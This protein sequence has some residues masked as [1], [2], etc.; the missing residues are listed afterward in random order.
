VKQRCDVGTA[1]ATRYVAAAEH[2]IKAVITAQA[3]L[4][5]AAEHVI[6]A[7]TTKEVELAR[8][9]QHNNGQAAEHS[10]ARL[11]LSNELAAAQH[12]EAAA[13]VEAQRQAETAA[14]VR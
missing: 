3:E 12:R 13:K 10:A 6:K 8:A 4:A 7:A 5:A 11:R 2:A 9:R 14:E 1:D